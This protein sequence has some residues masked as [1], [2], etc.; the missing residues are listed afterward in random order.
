MH[1]KCPPLQLKW[2]TSSSRNTH[3]MAA[4]DGQRAGLARPSTG[5]HGTPCFPGR[6]SQGHGPGLRPRHGPMGRF[7]CRAGPRSTTRITG[8]ASPRPVTLAFTNRSQFHRIS[9]TF[10]DHITVSYIH[11][12]KVS[13]I[14]RSL[15]HTFTESKSKYP[16]PIH[17][18]FHT[19]TESKSKCSIH[20]QITVSYILRIKVQMSDTFTVQQR[21]QI[22]NSKADR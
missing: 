22:S 9:N 7:S 6:A 21:Y 17:S 2:Y 1:S 18:Q 3:H 20:S 8:R 16:I 12:I 11:R 15:F 19:F 5:R 13:Y 10:T 14:H 4:I